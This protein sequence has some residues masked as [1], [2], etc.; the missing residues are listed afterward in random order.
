MLFLFL[1]QLPKVI[2]SGKYFKFICNQLFIKLCDYYLES[3]LK[4]GLS[5]NHTAASTLK[6]N[7]SPLSMKVFSVFSNTKM[8]PLG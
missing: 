1:L 2:V 4:D 6:T 7:S 5:L 3:I 8:F